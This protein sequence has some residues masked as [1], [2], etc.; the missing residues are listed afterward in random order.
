[1]HTEN[2]KSA[3]KVNLRLQYLSLC[4]RQGTAATAIILQDTI[5]LLEL[6]SEIT[7]C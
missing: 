6:L 1:M 4:Q 5:L 2:K 7:C 3:G